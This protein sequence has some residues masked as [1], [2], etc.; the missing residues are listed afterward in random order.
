MTESDWSTVK[1]LEEEMRMIPEEGLTENSV[2]VVGSQHEVGDLRAQKVTSVLQL[3]QTGYP[4]PIRISDSDHIPKNYHNF[5]APRS[6]DL[7]DAQ[8]RQ[9]HL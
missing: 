5:S 9:I 8:K 4:H 1:Q 7:R 6:H 2:A 3:F